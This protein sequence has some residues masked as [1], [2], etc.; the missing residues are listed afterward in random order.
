MEL[1]EKS[2]LN[3]KNFK[4]CI[5]SY[6]RKESKWLGSCIMQSKFKRGMD[7]FQ[8]RYSV[9]GLSSEYGLMVYVD[10]ARTVECS[11][12][13]LPYSSSHAN[14]TFIIPCSTPCSLNFEGMRI[15]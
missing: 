9:K 12:K 10:H 7:A 11:I 6:Q 2:N 1:N 8:K 3:N 4:A 13:S 15:Q 5:F 14:S